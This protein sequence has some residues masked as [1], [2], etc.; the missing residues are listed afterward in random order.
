MSKIV[1]NNDLLQLNF[2]C[3]KL[4]WIHNLCRVVLLLRIFKQVY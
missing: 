4:P 1:G 2:E 3:M